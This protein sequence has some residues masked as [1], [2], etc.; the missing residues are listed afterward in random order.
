MLNTFLQINNN[1][2]FLKTDL[3]NNYKHDMNNIII[4]NLLFIQR[5]C[6]YNVRIY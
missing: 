6:L 1:Y 3:Q 4:I 5:K 2:F